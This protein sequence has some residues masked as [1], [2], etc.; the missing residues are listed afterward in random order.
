[1]DEKKFVSIL[2][3]PK[4]Y[5]ALVE[6]GL[7]G[8]HTFKIEITAKV[9]EPCIFTRYDRLLTDDIYI[10]QAIEEASEPSGGIVK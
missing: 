10:I 3:W 1:M 4:L 5:D 9:G 7:V 6:K 2:D 8:K